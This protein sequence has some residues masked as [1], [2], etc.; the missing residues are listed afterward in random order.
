[1]KLLERFYISHGS[2]IWS[3]VFRLSTKLRHLRQTQVRTSQT[4]FRKRHLRQAAGKDSR[5]RLQ[6]EASKTDTG[7]RHL[8]RT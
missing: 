3:G 8:R 5:D 6:E 7:E 4:G 2:Y 1:M